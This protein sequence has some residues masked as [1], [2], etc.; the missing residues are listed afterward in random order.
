MLNSVTRTTPARARLSAEERRRQLLGI[1][2]RRLVDRPIHDL[3]LDE[4]AHEAGI[5]RGLLFHY[6]PTKG[7]YH[8][9]VLAAAAR[10]VRRNLTPE[11]GVTGE[12]ALHQLVGRYVAQVERR[13][14]FYVALVHGRVAAGDT[15][16]SG[17]AVE[18]LREQLTDLVLAMGLP[19]VTEAAEP[20]PVVH[21]WLAYVED[22]ALQWS[23]R[24]ADD[25]PPAEQLVAHCAA[26]LI[27]L[28]TA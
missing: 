4:V 10:R 9:E 17:E 26:A 18:S 27:T 11:E 12:E 16:D 2:L 24:P 21:G 19:A 5:S 13:R 20:R 6:F 7:A 23:A 8:A 1:G 15:G 28:L 14:D 22:R 3:S 25:R